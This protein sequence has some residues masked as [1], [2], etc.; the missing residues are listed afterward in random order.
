MPFKFQCVYCSQKLSAEG[1]EIGS[2]AVCPS[3]NKSIIVPPPGASPYMTESIKAGLGEHDE[4]VAKG[5]GMSCPTCWM[6]FGAGDLMQISVHESL[7]GDP[8]LGNNHMLRFFPKEYSSNGRPLDPKGV[9]VFETA[10]PFCRRQLPKKFGAIP[11]HIISVVGDQGSGKSYYLSTLT[12]QLGD[13]L[14]SHFKLRLRDADPSGNAVLNDMQNSILSATK[15]E[16]AIL[17][18]TKLEGDMYVKV[19]RHGRSMAYPRPFTYNV[20]NV[21][22]K[23]DICSLVLYDNAG[24]HYQPGVN[25]AESPGAL[26]VAYSNLIIFLFDPLN[27]IQ[28]GKALQKKA[29]E[30]ERKKIV[31]KHLTI[32]SEM[33]NRISTIENNYGDKS[34]EKM[35]AFVL[36]KFDAWEQLLGEE[37]FLDPIK[38]GK[39]N[40]DVLNQNSDRLKGLLMSICPSI[41]AAAESISK[42]C[43]FFAACP[44]GHSPVK[45]LSGLYAPD[46]SKINP[47]FVE[48][49]VI[50]FLNNKNYLHNNE[51]CQIK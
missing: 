34:G 25:I 11:Q 44:L 10:C 30:L 51:L 1:N 50:W 39:I 32:L 15:P 20:E 12:G 7:R 42:H 29:P 4:F 48:Q 28:F 21:V 47:K 23:Q 22:S 6:K 27:S 5:T 33:E 26:H 19:K 43:K 45:T 8:I 2:D 35:F 3:C 49:P 14:Y 46:P 13:V 37:P 9:P 40:L 36:N 24:E 41:V 17:A 38:D 18:K 31:D 16:D